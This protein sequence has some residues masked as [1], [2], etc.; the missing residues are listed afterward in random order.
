MRAESA[1]GEPATILAPVEFPG[2]GGSG[3]RTFSGAG[4][5]LAART[6]R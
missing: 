2:F 6:G 3:V 1:A 4:A 5:A